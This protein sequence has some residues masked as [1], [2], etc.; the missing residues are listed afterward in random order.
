[1]TRIFWFCSFAIG[2][3]LVARTFGVSGLESSETYLLIITALL[4]IGLYGSAFSID[5][6]EARESLKLIVSAVTIGVVLKALIVGGAM[7]VLT[8]DTKFFVIGI[9]VAQIDPLSV[10]SILRSSRMSSRAKTILAA[11]AS[12]DDPMTALLTVYGTIALG[13][14]IG[15][16]PDF[17]SGDQPGVDWNSYFINLS[18]NV[19]LTAGALLLWFLVRRSSVMLT[20][21]V[22][23]V[24][25]IAIE[26]F[27]MLGVATSGLFL[28]P[29]I[30]D[31]LNGVMR[32]ALPIAAMML[33]MVLVGGIDIVHGVL[34]GIATFTSQ[35]IVAPLLTRGLLK[36]DRIALAFAQQNG[37]TAIIL[38]LLLE[39]HYK[40]VIEVVA[41]A[42]IV[43]N[44]LHAVVNS[45]LD[46]K[47]ASTVA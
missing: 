21:S 12:F 5:L 36:S 34:L 42:I 28:R 19:A 23:G 14:F 11:W 10:A 38:S 33:G 44:V 2:G 22:F 8:R 9:A 41:P 20:A 40:G 39:V 47:I 30:G 17:F 25:G 3:Y 26:R 29:P 7:W 15:L 4:A 37:L 16:S 46:K 24:V 1:M 6:Q 32:I 43:V 31:F 35:I 18:E 27:L 45:H 13:S